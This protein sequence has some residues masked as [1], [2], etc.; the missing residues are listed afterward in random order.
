MVMKW[1]YRI[2]TLMIV[3]APGLMGLPGALA[4]GDGGDSAASL[5]TTREKV[6]FMG[7]RITANPADYLL[8]NAA[9]QQN[10]PAVHDVNKDEKEE[11][12]RDG[13]RKPV[14]EEEGQLIAREPGTACGNK[15]IC[16]TVMILRY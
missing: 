6:R 12:G 5:N 8:L 2:A 3:L 16:R 1:K 7:Y 13:I 14:S 10:R 15:G 11:Y 9:K 4:I